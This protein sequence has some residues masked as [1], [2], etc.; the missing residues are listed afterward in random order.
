[1]SA[2]RARLDPWL[3]KPKREQTAS[4]V[5][6]VYRFASELPPITPLRLKVEIN[7]REHLRVLPLETRPFAAESRWFTGRASIQTYGIEE[8]LGT[9]L[10]ALYQRKKGRDL[11]DLA[12][13]LQRVPSLACGN[14]AEC[15]GRY[16]AHGGN[17]ISRAEFEENLAVK[18]SDAAFLGDIGPLLVPGSGDAYDAAAAGALVLGKLVALLPGDPWRRPGATDGAPLSPE[19]GVRGRR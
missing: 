3:G 10:R 6:L 13:A 7:T 9:K 1:M 12:T 14:I 15:F 19:A 5:R 4:A 17:R 11:F 18:M 2:L 8:L 16:L